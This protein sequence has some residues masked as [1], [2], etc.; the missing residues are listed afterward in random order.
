MV[1]PRLVLRAKSM[2]NTR[3]NVF[4]SERLSLWERLYVEFWLVEKRFRRCEI[5][6]SNKLTT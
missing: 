4:S 3:Q 1:V 6:L 5:I 2:V